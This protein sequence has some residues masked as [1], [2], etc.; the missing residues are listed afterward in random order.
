MPKKPLQISLIAVVYVLVLI[1][2]YFML[3]TPYNE[4]NQLER[5]LDEEKQAQ[6]VLGTVLNKRPELIRSTNMIQEQIMHYESKLPRAEDLPMVLDLINQFAAKLDI[7]IKE[8]LDRSLTM[9]DL[10]A[11]YPIYIEA[12]GSFAALNQLVANLVE[13]MPSIEIN[14]L[15]LTSITDKDITLCMDLNLHIIGEDIT[16]EYEWQAD[17]LQLVDNYQLRDV[18]GAPLSVVTQLYDGS[19]EVLGIIIS[20]TDSR[21]LIA[22]LGEQQWLHTGDYVGNAEL[23]SIESGKVTLDFDGIEMIFSMEGE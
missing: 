21:A 19:F 15:S 9:S 10:D 20:N 13:L 8:L 4:A 22:Y 2:L 1:S 14:Y 16:T 18:F 23:K 12:E 5:L 6:A 7:N 17:T 11:W 3:W